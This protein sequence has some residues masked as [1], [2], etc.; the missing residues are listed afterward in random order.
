MVS[1]Q[2]T[3]RPVSGTLTRKK[4]ACWTGPEGLAG[5]WRRRDM[6]NRRTHR[7]QRIH[8]VEDC[9]PARGRWL[10]SNQSVTVGLLDPHIKQSR[11]SGPHRRERA[12][13][14]ALT[15]RSTDAATRELTTRFPGTWDDR[16]GR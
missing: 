16:P 3:A 9:G 5:D 14:S 12:W 6:T 13:K 1:L 7:E 15:G 4:Q 8:D 2:R 10:G 11:S